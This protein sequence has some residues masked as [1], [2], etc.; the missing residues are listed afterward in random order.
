MIT[1][2]INLEIMLVNFHMPLNV[3]FTTTL[4]KDL[5]I[6]WVVMVTLHVSHLVWTTTQ[7]CN[8]V[9]VTAI[10]EFKMQSKLII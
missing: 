9:D 6:C 10:A 2:T 3:L 5:R 8:V 7:F 1:G 4:L